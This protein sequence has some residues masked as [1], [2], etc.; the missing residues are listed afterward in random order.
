MY[1]VRKGSQLFRVLMA[2]LRAPRIQE[3]WKSCFLPY[4]KNFSNLRDLIEQEDPFS[5]LRWDLPL[6]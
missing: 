4:I 5:G 3:D 2:Q 6:L 1:R